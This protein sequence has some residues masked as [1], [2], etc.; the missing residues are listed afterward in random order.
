MQMAHAYIVAT[1]LT[2]PACVLHHCS[3]SARPFKTFQLYCPTHSKV[4]VWD[5]TPSATKRGSNVEFPNLPPDVLA[6]GPRASK[7]TPDRPTS[8]RGRLGTVTLQ[9]PPASSHTHFS[10]FQ[11]A[12]FENSSVPHTKNFVSVWYTTHSFSV[13]EMQHAGGIPGRPANRVRISRLNLCQNEVSFLKS[14]HKVKNDS[15]SISKRCISNDR[16]RRLT[17]IF[18]FVHQPPTSLFV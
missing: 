8:H 12:I 13:W 18:F 16:Q 1:P 5:N 10:E 9:P 17:S 14:H 2:V 3:V 11:W 7:Y 15:S 4:S 6:D